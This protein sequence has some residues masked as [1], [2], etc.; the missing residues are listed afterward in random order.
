MVSRKTKIVQAGHKHAVFV[1]IY[2]RNR[3]FN[4]NNTTNVH[5][6]MLMYENVT[7]GLSA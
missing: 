4:T 6:C 2:S 7:Y 5:E 1:F 3:E